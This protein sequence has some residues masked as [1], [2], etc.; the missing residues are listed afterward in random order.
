M[1]NARTKVTGGVHCITRRT[2]EGKAEC[3]DKDT[4]DVRAIARNHVA[5]RLREDHPDDEHQEERS[6]ELAEER[7]ASQRG[8][9]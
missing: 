5:D 8:L 1:R 3:P 9:S 7:R 6:D 4:D 2:T